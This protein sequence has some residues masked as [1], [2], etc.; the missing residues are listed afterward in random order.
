[1]GLERGP[2]S[3]VSTT[4]ELSKEKKNKAIPVIGRGGLQGCEMLKIPHCLDNRLT[5]GGKAVSPTH[6]PHFTPQKH[7]YFSISGTHFCYMLSKLQ[8]LVP[9]EGLGT[10]KN[11]PHRVSN[12]REALL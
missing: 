2:L 8:G 3:L 10:F 5:Y 6:W 9:P 11:S 12:P 4:E 7:Y 1:V